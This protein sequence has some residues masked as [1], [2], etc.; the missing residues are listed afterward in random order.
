MTIRISLLC[1]PATA[2]LRAG[3]FP[4]DEPLDAEQT[5]GLATLAA[6]A[7]FSFDAPDQVLCSPMRCARDAVGA[8]GFEARTEAALREMDYGRWAGLS[9]KQVGEAEPDAL[10]AWLSDPSVAAHGGESLRV[11][12]ARVAHWAADYPWAPGHTLVMTHA[13]VIKAFVVQLLKAPEQAYRQL[14]IAPLTLTTVSVHQ[15]QWRLASAGVP[16]Y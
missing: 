14:D 4:A 15:G 2:A 16:A 11:L 3:R 7:A 6:S 10:A 5:D 1:L 12:L 9:L 8:L 13:S